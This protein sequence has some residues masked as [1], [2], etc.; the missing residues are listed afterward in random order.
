MHR[1]PGKKPIQ[2]VKNLAKRHQNLKKQPFYPNNT[3]KT[4]AIQTDNQKFWKF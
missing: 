4:V 3:L 2:M 1:K